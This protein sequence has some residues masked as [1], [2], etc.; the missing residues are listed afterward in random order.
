MNDQTAKPMTRDQ[1]IK[2][3]DKLLSAISKKHEEVK[4]LKVQLLPTP[5]RE[6]IPL[7]ILNAGAREQR[8]AKFTEVAR[9]KA[10]VTMAIDRAAPKT[11]DS[12]GKKN[13]TS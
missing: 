8:M 4:A 10:A 12:N 1:I 7:H 2:H 9:I 13:A 5:A 3:N 11:G 6:E